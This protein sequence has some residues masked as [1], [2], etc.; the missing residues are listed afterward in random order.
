MKTWKFP[1]SIIISYLED[2]SKIIKCMIDKLKFPDA[3][4]R[5]IIAIYAKLTVVV[6]LRLMRNV[7][8]SIGVAPGHGNT[9]G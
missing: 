2:I 5:E 8:V 6:N 9:G 4:V 3:T 7:K 1:I